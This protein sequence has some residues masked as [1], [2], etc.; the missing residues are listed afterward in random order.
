VI[1]QH[2]N[3]AETGPA[4]HS[5]SLFAFFSLRMISFVIIFIFSCILVHRING[6][7]PFYELLFVGLRFW[8]APSRADVDDVLAASTPEAL[9]AR[10]ADVFAPQRAFTWGRI[11]NSPIMMTRLA[12]SKMLWLEELSHLSTACVVVILSSM[13][14]S[15]VE[16]YRDESS[17]IVDGL[18]ACVMIYA[19]L[20]LYNVLAAL[21]WKSPDSVGS[22]YAAVIASVV[23]ALL[24]VGTYMVHPR[25]AFIDLGARLRSATEGSTYSGSPLAKA[26]SLEL[27]LLVAGVA[28]FVGFCAAV[29]WHPALLVSQFFDRRFAAAARGAHPWRDRLVLRTLYFF[30][31]I[32]VAVWTKWSSDNVLPFD[33]IL[34]EQGAIARDCR[35][36]FKD[37]SREGG[38]AWVALIPFFI[39]YVAMSHVVPDFTAALSASTWVSESSWLRI[40][41]AFVFAYAIMHLALI[42]FQLQT[43][44]NGASEEQ[45]DAIRRVHRNGSG[46]YK[47][48]AAPELP[49]TTRAPEAPLV[50]EFP[51][52]TVDA[53]VAECDEWAVRT[54]KRAPLLAAEFLAMSA[55]FGS[56][57][58]LL[59]RRG[60]L[61]GIGVCSAAR[62]LLGKRPP[63]AMHSTE[64]LFNLYM[65]VA[66]Y[67]D[68]TTA[69][70]ILDILWNIGDA[71]LT[72]FFWRPVLSFII[73]ALLCAYYIELEVG[74]MF[75]RV[76]DDAAHDNAEAARNAASNKT[77]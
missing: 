25:D 46:K 62:A 18:L 8:R 21:P 4:L 70:E 65:I 68:T 26:L 42:R 13:F 7:K 37:A 23:T 43:H 35:E 24:L 75:W 74:L 10:L 57:S 53:L 2:Q 14:T 5:L 77:K 60:G 48:L 22:R 31:L 17:Y 3:K 50:S 33:A 44:L 63:P 52:A 28:T 34:C 38:S 11:F 32:L 67:A 29:S 58:L 71:L 64:G 56:L 30:P 76:S 73:F 15:V 51:L 54:L 1:R 12:L 39:P 40:R 66:Q 27:I 59:V 16:C 55:L 36:I 9:E 41:A 45:K 20:M 49:K 47:A 6:R 72:P 61:G 19:L 69:D